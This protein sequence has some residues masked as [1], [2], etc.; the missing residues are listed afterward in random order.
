MK[1]WEDFGRKMVDFVASLDAS[2]IQFLPYAMTYAQHI[3]VNIGEGKEM[4]YTPEDA[5]RT[6]MLYVINN[7]KGATEEEF[8]EV[9]DM[10]KEVSVDISKAIEEMLNSED[11]EL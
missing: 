7:L 8:M 6:Q 9:Q 10:C 11:E 5:T 4:G 2:K 1:K 3:L